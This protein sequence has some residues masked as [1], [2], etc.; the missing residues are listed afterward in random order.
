MKKNVFC[1]L[2][3]SL[4][5]TGCGGGTSSS[6]PTSASSG[7]ENLIPNNFKENLLGTYYSGEGTI[8]V[9]EE[10]VKF[11]DLVLQPTKYQVESFNETVNSKLKTVEHAVTYL[12]NNDDIYRIYFQ[13]NEGLYKLILEKK[14]KSGYVQVSLFMPSIE[15]FT[16]SFNAY[17]D[18]NQYNINYHIGN[19]FNFYRG[20]FDIGLCGVY[21]G[22]SQDSYYVESYYTVNTEGMEKVISIYDY[23]DNFEYYRVKLGTISNVKGLVDIS[24]SDPFI[25]F[26]Y[27]P[28]YLTYP[29]FSNSSSFESGS[30][31]VENK[32]ITINEQTYSYE[33]S[34][35]DKGQIV[36]LTNENK[37][38]T[39]RPTQYGMIWTENNEDTEYVYNSVSNLEGDYQYRDETYSFNQNYETFEY[40]LLINGSETSFSYEVYNHQKA[41]KVSVNNKVKYFT[42]FKY[43]IAIMCSDDSRDT[44]FV[45]QSAFSSL[46]NYTFINKE[47]ETSEELTISS[48]FEVNYKNSESNSATIGTLLYDPHLLYPYVE[49]IVSDVKYEFMLLESNGIARLTSNDISKD[50]FIQEDVNEI[51]STYTSK[52]ES[53]ITINNQKITYFCNTTNYKISA[54]YSTNTYSY[55]MSID[56]VNENKTM[57][58]FPSKGMIEIT[59]GKKSTTF[60][61]IEG[62]NELVGTYCYDGEFGVEKF[63]LTSDGHFYADTLNSSKDGIIK[64]VEYDYSLKMSYDYANN[65]Y[66]TIVFYYDNKSSLDLVLKDNALVV[67]GT[68]NYTADYLYQ[69][70]G[71]YVDSE[72]T[73]VIELRENSLYVDGTKVT[74]KEVTY[75]NEH[76]Y[77]TANVNFNEVTYTFTKN[78]DKNVASLGDNEL[79]FEE[80]SIDSLIGE[81][82]YNETT[83]EVKKVD[84][85]Y[86]VTN[87]TTTSTGYSVVIYDNHI[88]IKFTYGLDTIYV[89]STSEGNV[90]VYEAAA[91]PPLPPIL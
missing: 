53:E 5:L 9:D 44:F 33:S 84:N 2:V 55:I 38:I 87:G 18:S 82:E 63:R 13:G 22:M 14:E 31:D 90:L 59:D 19:D 16:G 89:Y 34:S 57:Q 61:D 52:C 21:Y 27:D 46:Y 66:P 56:F 20:Y 88:A 24:T 11:N 67:G 72:T 81:Y 43:T 23:A 68:L 73:S 28:M 74:I 36:T 35:D 83:Y 65:A 8:I 91:L 4:L 47:Y 79:T 42:P 86:V 58:G 51:Y 26:Y 45:N 25:A 54:Y 78:E 3:L 71:I 40:E 49:F 76:T 70:Q 50:F 62:F 37:T 69:Y 32:T 64:D 85:N 39:T 1:F 77:V 75:D 48:G 6:N 12:K 80:I 41:I 10:S 60:I 15:E 17:G 7:P 30:I 29:Y